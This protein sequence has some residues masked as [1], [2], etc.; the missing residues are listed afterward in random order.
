MCAR[1]KTKSQV[2]GGG[3]RKHGLLGDT[4]P[5]QIDRPTHPLCSRDLM[6]K[7]S[8]GMIVLMSS[9]LNFLKMVV[10]PALS[11]PL[12]ITQAKEERRKEERGGREAEEGGR[13]EAGRQRKEGNNDQQV[14]FYA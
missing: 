14:L 11:S 2:C 7:P 6:L 9:P 4:K 3:E 5:T 13:G 1:G 10:F 12:F 8:V